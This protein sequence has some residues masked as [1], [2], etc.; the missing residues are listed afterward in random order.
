M[1][2][3]FLLFYQNSK[4]L[5][6][7]SLAIDLCIYSN[8]ANSPDLC[9]YMPKGNRLRILGFARFPFARDSLPLAAVFPAKS[10]KEA[11]VLDLLGST[12]S[13]SWLVAAARQINMTWTTES[14]TG[15]RIRLAGKLASRG[16]GAAGSSQAQDLEHGDEQP[17]P[18]RGHGNTK[19][20]ARH[21][22]ARARKGWVHK[23]LFLPS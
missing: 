4:N 3:P 16:L 2:L 8:L 13:P 21:K 23:T 6:P 5:L 20:I 15:S 11:R 19:K 9:A 1:S 12:P 7:N 10:S 18:R 14:P 17:G 22:A